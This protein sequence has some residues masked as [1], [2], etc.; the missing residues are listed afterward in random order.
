MPQDAF[1]FDD[2]PVEAAGQPSVSELEA[3]TRDILSKPGAQ[4][5]L[6]AQRGCRVSGMVISHFCDKTSQ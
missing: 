1:G 2:L 4:K 6:S 3:T 5:L